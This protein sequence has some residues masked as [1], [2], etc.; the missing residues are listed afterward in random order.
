MK[1]ILIPINTGLGNA[2]LILPLLRTLKR[3]YKNSCIDLYGG[4]QFGADELFKY[5][6]DINEIYY[7]LPRKK[8]DLILSPFLGGGD[9]FAI[10]MKMRNMFSLVISHSFVGNQIKGHIKELI[11]KL[12]RIKTVRFNLLKHES[13]N[14]LNLL[15]ILDGDNQQ[16]EFKNLMSPGVLNK[17]N[18]LILKFNL[19]E[20]Y[21]AIQL[22]V[23][24]NQSDPRMWPIFKWKLIIEEMIKKR[25]KV[26][27]LGD[28]N[29]LGLGNQIEKEHNKGSVINLIGKT[30][31]PE[32]MGVIN[33]A[34]LILGVDSGIAHISGALNKKTL[35]LWGPSIFSKSHPVGQHIHYINLHKS[36]APC[37][38]PALYSPK[39]AIKYC[40]NKIKCMDDIT[41][42]QVITEI[43][44][45]L[46]N[47]Q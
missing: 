31:I 8:Y 13:W 37:M 27:L 21:I 4:K 43:E 39:D 15:S 23:A 40:P 14:N 17:I 25:V 38:G 6:E 41:S 33:K 32:L 34:T 10:K 20:Q 22:G 28:K 35:I 26:V 3:V 2:V 19:P 44:A 12:F 47:D 18:Q 11:Y 24:N 1:K 9:Y 42:K 7:T 45:L 5:D 30:T 46:S 16:Y 36:C 29:E